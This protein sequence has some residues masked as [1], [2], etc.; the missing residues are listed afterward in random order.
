MLPSERRE[1]LGALSPKKVYLHSLLKLLLVELLNLPYL[2]HCRGWSA[3]PSFAV[4]VVR[5]RLPGFTKLGF[6]AFLPSR[7]WC[8]NALSRDYHKAG[9]IF[10]V[11]ISNQERCLEIVVVRYMCMLRALVGLYTSSD[12][13]NVLFWTHHASIAPIM[14]LLKAADSWRPE[15][16]RRSR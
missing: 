4:C 10:N 9:I 11:C 16:G 6:E 12:I 1:L 3:S 2:V 13:R 15:N 8:R 7:L 5:T 14:R